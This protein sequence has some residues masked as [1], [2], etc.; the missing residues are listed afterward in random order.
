MGYRY[1]KKDLECNFILI[2]L[3]LSIFN[4]LIRIPNTVIT[5]YRF[6]LPIIFLIS[7]YY[8][9]Y[10]YQFFLFVIFLMFSSIMQ[11]IVFLKFLEFEQVFDWEWWIRYLIHYMSIVAIFMMIHLLRIKNRKIFLQMFYKGINFIGPLIMVGYFVACMSTSPKKIIDNRNNYGCGLAVVFPWYFIC[12]MYGRWRYLII[13]GIIIFE[14]FWGDSKAVLVGILLE[15]GVIIITR[16]SQKS[17][18]G[19]KANYFFFP[20]ILI[21]S[22]S[23]AISPIRING[24]VIRDMFLGMFSHILKG[25][26][27][28]EE[29]SSLIYRTNAIVHLLKVMTQSYFLGIGPGNSGKALKYL[30]PKI[31]VAYEADKILSPHNT[32]LEFFCDCGIWSILLCIWVGLKAMRKLFQPKNLRPID[33]YYVAFTL[34]FPMWVMSASGIYTI[35]I[36]FIVIAWLYENNKE[37]CCQKY[38]G[39]CRLE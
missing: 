22:I 27:Y 31:A 15:M 20:I 9:Q 12:G 36:I 18:E 35:Y 1:K 6:L 16:I 26:L 21:L 11:N 13:C 37:D 24:Y 3:F 8:I 2:V 39:V 23:I 14:L 34:S 7:L 4:D 38:K 32:L 33:I 19:K 10:T 30:M 29:A 28:V 25:E 5:G 17:K